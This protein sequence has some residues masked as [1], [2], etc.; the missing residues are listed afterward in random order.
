[1]TKFARLRRN[2]D[3]KQM[4]KNCTQGLKSYMLM[5]FKTCK[6]LRWHQQI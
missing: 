5:T 6:W 1:M 4:L 2:P 3:I